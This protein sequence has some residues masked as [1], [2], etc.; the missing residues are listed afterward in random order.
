VTFPVALGFFTNCLTFGLGSLAVC[1]AVR[2]LADSDALGAVEHFASFVRALDFAFRFFALDVAN[3]VFG[4]GARSV[5]FW[6]FADGVADGGAV[7]IVA[8]PRALGMALRF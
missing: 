5:T 3:G 1:H 8:L 2:S 7:G 4:F 6:W